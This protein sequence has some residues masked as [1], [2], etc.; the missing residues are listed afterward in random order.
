MGFSLYPKLE[1]R[2]VKA[3]YEISE[4]TTEKQAIV[5]RD[6]LE[7]NAKSMIKDY[8]LENSIISTRSRSVL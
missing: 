3:N 6:T 5:L 7:N 8:N 1:G 2:W 4:T